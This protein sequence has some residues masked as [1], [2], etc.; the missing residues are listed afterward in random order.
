MSHLVTRLGDIT[1]YG[2]GAFSA[3]VVVRPQV[4][5]PDYPD[6]R[7]QLWMP[8]AQ[9]FAISQ[10][11]LRHENALT[12]F[13]EYAMFVLLWRIADHNKGLVERCSVCWDDIAEAYGQ[14]PRE[15]CEGCFGTTFE[16]GFKARI[17]RPSL[18]DAN[19]AANVSHRRGETETANTS[20][21]TTEDFRARS[22]D[23]VFRADGTRWR[24][25]SLSTNHLRTGFMMPSV[26]RTSVGFNFGQVMLEDRSS[27]AYT[28]PPGDDAFEAMDLMHTHHPRDFSDYEIIRGSLFHDEVP[29]NG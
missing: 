19:E 17:I 26:P 7:L 14:S 18:W 20:I 21:Q 24:I 9:D 3:P 6:G 16:G 5:W 27:V 29:V 22:G 15:K 13:G 12:L 11:A 2:E 28:I 23:F 8:D 1:A 10:V 25:Q 4:P